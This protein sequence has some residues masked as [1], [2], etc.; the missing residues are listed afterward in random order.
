MGFRPPGDAATREKKTRAQYNAYMRAYTLKW[1][2][3]A[4]SK[5]GGK[6]VHCG[7]SDVRALQFNHKAG[8]GGREVSRGYSATYLRR[9]ADG[10]RP[11]IELVCANCNQIHAVEKGL[12]RGGPKKYRGGD[13]VG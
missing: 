2:L 11:D 1:K 6:C 13:L 5:L 9:I 8:G 3:E 12:R 4:I 7:F 10:M